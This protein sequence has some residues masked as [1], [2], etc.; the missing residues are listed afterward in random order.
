MDNASTHM[1]EEVDRMICDA[2]A[3]LLYT[4]LYSPHLNPIEKMS[5]VYKMHLKQ[6][7]LDFVNNPIGTHWRAL[8][9]VT[10]DIAIKEFRKCKV[11]YSNDIKTSEEEN[12]INSL[13]DQGQAMNKLYLLMSD[14]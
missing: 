14:D 11:P 13:N 8:H 10:R 9:A 6:N 12:D 1:D 5:N 7:K 4:A 2:G 3:L